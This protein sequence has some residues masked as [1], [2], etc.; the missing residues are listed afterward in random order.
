L[1]SEFDLAMKQSAGETFTKIAI[2]VA[3]GLVAW[4]CMTVVHELGHIVGGYISGAKLLSAE[5]RPWKIP[6]SFFEPDPHPLVTLWSGPVLG[7]LVPFL[8]AL[9]LPFLRA[10]T[11]DPSPG[12]PGEGRRLRPRRLVIRDSPLKFVA[13]FCILANGCYL[14]VAWFTG[15]HHLDTARLLQAGSHP[16]WIL[17]YCL[18]TIG[19]GYPAFRRDC[20][21]ILK[22]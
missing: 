9:L 18:L 21:A 3:L 8:V 22:T 12:R 5:L 4:C 1:L 15:D 13:D 17:A 20:R 10:L 11:P 16:I 7:A 2:F 19:Y 6:F 14:A